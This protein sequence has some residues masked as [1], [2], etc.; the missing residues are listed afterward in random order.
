MAHPALTVYK[1][2]AQRPTTKAGRECEHLYLHASRQL[3]VRYRVSLS[4]MTVR[5]IAAAL[6]TLVDQ[7]RLDFG[8]LRAELDGRDMREITRLLCGSAAAPASLAMRLAAQRR[9]QAGIARLEHIKPA[10]DG[11]RE[12]QADIATATAADSPHRGPHH[13][14][15]ARISRHHACGGALGTAFSSA[16]AVAG[17]LRR[18]R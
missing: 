5:G 9:L 1:N 18:N 10:R 3:K 13:H 16:S 15:A 11:R 4:G 2:G 17:P 8:A 14:R 6:A 12:V 7:G